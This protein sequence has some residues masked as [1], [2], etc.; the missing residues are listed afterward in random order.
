MNKT[1]VLVFTQK[2][3][4]INFDDE[5]LQRVNQASWNNQYPNNNNPIVKCGFSGSAFL[6]PIDLNKL[7]DEEGV[8]LVYDSMDSNSF[9]ILKQQCAGDQVYLLTHSSGIWKQ[10]NFINWKVFTLSGTHNNRDED[11]YYP[12]FDILT[13]SM[14]DKMNRIVN[15]IFKPRI[16]MNSIYQFMLGCSVPKNQ[17]PQ[18]QQA[19]QSLL[20]IDGLKEEVENFYNHYKDCDQE[21]DYQ[22]AF[23]E[24]EVFFGDFMR[25]AVF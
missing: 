22:E 10:N 20:V 13:D 1:K 23:R 3:K 6:I 4:W 15:T 16:L 12:L 17:D 19:Y 7:F 8:F 9:M 25:N 21:E 5:I 11:I 14:G 2:G 24:L 18:L